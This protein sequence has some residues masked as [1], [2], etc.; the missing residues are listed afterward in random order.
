MRNTRANVAGHGRWR[1]ATS[2][3]RRRG[4]RLKNL[5]VRD[6]FLTVTLNAGVLVHRF[7][8][9]LPA[10]NV[11]GNAKVVVRALLLKHNDRVVQTFTYRG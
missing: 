8:V 4:R 11:V 10:I 1:V 6:A 7:Q 2:V 9:H 3:Q 5:L